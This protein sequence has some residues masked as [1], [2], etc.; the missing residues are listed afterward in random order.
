[1]IIESEY[2]FGEMVYLVHDTEQLQRMVVGVN[3][4][5]KY[6]LYELAC[7]SQAPSLHLSILVLGEEADK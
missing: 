4:Y 3:A 6:N 5:P 1:M 2:E 7:G